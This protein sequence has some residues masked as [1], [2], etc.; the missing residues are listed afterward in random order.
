MNI[1]SKLYLNFR[2]AKNYVWLGE[3]PAT[4][5]YK[6]LNYKDVKKAQVQ[7]L[8]GLLEFVSKNNVYY[9]NLFSQ[10]NINVRNINIL[11][12]LK[13]IPI[14][15][16]DILR[17]KQKELLSA[18]IKNFFQN[19]T[20]G[21]TGEPV[22]F[23]QTRKY[24][25]HNLFDRWF[26]LKMMGY[27][28]GDKIVYL[29]GSDYDSKEHKNFKGKLI[30]Y[31]ENI[32][33]LNTFN[34]Q[35]IDVENLV[36][37][38]QNTKFFLAGYVSSVEFLARSLLAKK[39]DFQPEA[40]QVTAETLTLSQKKIIEE[41][42]GAKTFN[43][44]GSR[45]CG[46]IAHEC[47]V[48]AGFHIFSLSNL[49][50]F[51]KDN[52]T[53]LNKII[54]TNLNNYATPFI[55]YEIGDFADEIISEECQCGFPTSRIKNIMG[56]LG[57]NIKTPSGK[58]LHSEFFTHLFYKIQGVKQFQIIQKTPEVL[59]IKIVRD[60][61]FDEKNINFLEKTIIKNGDEKFKVESMACR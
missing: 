17:T 2:K 23:F 25:I 50:E 4:F 16:R 3:K 1:L 60:E 36:Q 35:K 45:E 57:E 43:R 32:Y 5:F 48:H 51:E 14:L 6:H 46:I 42:L 52:E 53:G 13:Q 18:G 41:T 61:N 47:K 30:D 7:K 49:V 8:I 55:R 21:S 15:T 40:I 22:S 31:L 56:R 28:S 37:A 26:A 27:E 34:I 9:K 54:V 58:T 20:G 24:G 19:Q 39:V 59:C 44:Y 38:M 29:W 10:Y 11:D 33:F 12:D